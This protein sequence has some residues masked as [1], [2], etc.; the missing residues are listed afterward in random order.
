MMKII[1]QTDV[2]MF[3]AFLPYGDE[4]HRL[5]EREDQT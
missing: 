5:V 2:L 4:P 1:I 3:F